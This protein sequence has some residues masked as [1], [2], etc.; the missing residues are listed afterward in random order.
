[1]PK[2]SRCSDAP[3]PSGSGPKGGTDC[4]NGEGRTWCT[5][6]NVLSTFPVKIPS[7]AFYGVSAATGLKSRRMGSDAALLAGIDPVRS[8]G[9]TGSLAR[10]PAVPPSIL[11]LL[12]C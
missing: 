3:D 4:E 6:R 12:P 1:M 10:A 11:V 9:A 8:H 7:R 5:P 2:T